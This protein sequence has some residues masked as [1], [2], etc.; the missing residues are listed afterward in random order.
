[1]AYEHTPDSHQTSDTRELADGEMSPV[2]QRK[3]QRLEANLGVRAGETVLDTPGGTLGS[4]RRNPLLRELE[5][6]ER[7][8]IIRAAD[9]TEEPTIPSTNAVTGT[10]LRGDIRDVEPSA[11]PTEEAVPSVRVREHIGS[12]ATSDVP[13]P[14][15]TIT[16][17]SE[18]NPSQV[19]YTFESG[20]ETKEPK[21]PKLSAV[22]VDGHISR[23][24]RETTVTY[25]ENGMPHIE[26][27]DQ[28][29]PPD[30]GST[31]Q[32]LPAA[33]HQLRHS[34]EAVN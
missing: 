2:L 19:T 1:M 4:Y 22:E 7:T 23:T 16:Y 8:G 21:R 6:H 14:D 12:T 30:G 24:P 32:P 29:P 18:L 33:R 5:E 15:V 11:H 28:S 9:Y 10:E 17:S 13:S 20:V 3:R 34:R 26:R 25:D 31:A 27:K